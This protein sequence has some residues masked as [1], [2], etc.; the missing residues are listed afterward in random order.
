MKEF[1]AVFIHGQGYTN[2]PGEFPR[3]SNHGRMEIAAARHLPEKGIS[4]KNYVFS[5]FTF[6]GQTVPLA[7]V[8]ARELITKNDIPP[9]LVIPD[10]TAQTT[11]MEITVFKRIAD[12]KGWNSLLDITVDAHQKEV[13]LLTQRIFRGGRRVA[14]LSAEEILQSLPDDEERLRYTQQI[15][16]MKRSKSELRL[17]AYEGIKYP[18]ISLPNGEKILEK[19]SEF[20]RPDPS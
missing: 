13:E 18:I 12:E 1:D 11:S 7:E 14:V 20:Y 19:L 5:G 17:R 16:R 8:N 4:V 9:G 3:P 2:L 6:P 10:D 15:R